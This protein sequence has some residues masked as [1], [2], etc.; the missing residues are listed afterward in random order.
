MRPMLVSIVERDWNQ[1]L[2]YGKTPDCGG[3]ELVPLVR[4]MAGGILIKKPGLPGMGFSKKLV[5]AYA[6]AATG[7]PGF[8]P[9]LVT[10]TLNCRLYILVFCKMFNATGA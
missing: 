6:P 1:P 10:V 4:N 5:K 9:A 3:G 8:G 2:L 7:G